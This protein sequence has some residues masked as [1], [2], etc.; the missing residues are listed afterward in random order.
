MNQ[1][2]NAQNN[3]YSVLIAVYANDDA[4]LF[5]NALSS[6]VS[7]SVLP[8]DVVLVQDGPI[9]VELDSVL[10][11]YEAKLPLKIIRLTESG[12]LGNALKVGLRHC[13]NDL[14]GRADSDDINLAHRF[15][16]Q[17]EFMN[18][19]QEVDVL[20]SNLYESNEYT[21]RIKKVPNRVE[22]GFKTF[23]RNPINHQTVMFRKRA[24]LAVGGYEDCSNFEDYL[25]WCRLLRNGSKIANL[26]SPLVIANIDNLIEKRSGRDYATKERCFYAKLADL[27]PNYKLAIILA[28]SS[29]A[30]LRYI[31]SSIIRQLYKLLRN[32]D[33]KDLQTLVK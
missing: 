27:F 14:V 31:P 21:Q 25:L 7:Q 26:N 30:L 19:N 6:L 3:N 11:E 8:A 32:S 23:F 5:S 2:E 12:G 24:V 20:G 28:G 16:T 33:D 1:I 4:N 17:V 13:Q 29:R 22:L 18:Q 9:T 15:V 10:I